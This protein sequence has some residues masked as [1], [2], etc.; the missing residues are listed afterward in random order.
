MCKRKRSLTGSSLSGLSSA[1]DPTPDTLI[2]PW[3]SSPGRK[4]IVD[5][6]RKMNSNLTYILIFER[7]WQNVASS[8]SPSNVSGLSSLNASNFAGNI[9]SNISSNVQ[10]SLPSCS[11][12]S[13]SHSSIPSNPSNL[14]NF[15]TPPSSNSLET[16]M[17]EDC[18]Q[19]VPTDL[20]SN[21]N[22]SSDGRSSNNNTHSSKRRHN[23]STSILFQRSSTSSNTTIPS[24][25]L[26]IQI[27]FPLLIL[28]QTIQIQTI[29]KNFI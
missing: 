20:N 9:L 22:S 13:P 4:R 27:V 29:L 23:S 28:L 25:N 19:E 1:D 21:N 14:S 11:I 10:N 12:T 3:C 5:F 7:I 8:V 16:G 17:T 2:S 18:S 15:S 24:S 26:L 6:P